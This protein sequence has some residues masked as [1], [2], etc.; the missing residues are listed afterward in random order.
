MEREK[1][2]GIW[3]VVAILAAGAFIMYADRTILYPM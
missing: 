2:T 3:P 1:E